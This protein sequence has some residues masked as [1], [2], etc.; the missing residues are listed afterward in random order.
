[1]LHV[2]GTRLF[3][4]EVDNE[5]AAELFE[6]LNFSR[7]CKVNGKTRYGY[8]LTDQA[9][10]PPIRQPVLQRDRDYYLEQLPTK[11]RH[12]HAHLEEQ[13]GFDVTGLL[14]EQWTTY[15]RYGN[16]FFITATFSRLPETNQ[17]AFKID[18]FNLA[19]GGHVGY[20]DVIISHESNYA[21]QD[22]AVTSFP[23]IVPSCAA[24]ML[25]AFPELRIDLANTIRTGWPHREGVWVQLNYRRAG[26]GQTLERIAGDVCKLA[27]PEVNTLG[28][29][30]PL[31]N[32]KAYDFHHQ[33]GAR[34]VSDPL[35]CLAY[36]LDHKNRPLIA[37]RYGL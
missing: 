15:Q 19:D 10:N 8:L 20:S 21:V 37:I 5:E 3:L 28:I 25:K 34:S 23:S 4:A 36:H 1:M 18:L 26:V 14:R 29:I 24:G 7:I 12:Y 9:W 33:S 30:F 17:A 22:N 16:N 11:E 2:G 13:S 6:R 32:L 27:F 35:Y 31:H